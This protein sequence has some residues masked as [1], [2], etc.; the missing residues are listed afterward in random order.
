LPSLP[1]QWTC[2]KDFF[3]SIRG[4]IICYLK[5]TFVLTVEINNSIAVL[6]YIV[7]NSEKGFFYRWIF[8]SRSHE[9]RT[10]AV[11]DQWQTEDNIELLIINLSEDPV[12][13]AEVE[14]TVEKNKTSGVKRP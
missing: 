11:R 3:P 9:Q 8:L 14:L 12:R 4:K 13:R 10:T 2:P 1:S 6:N 5:L 7:L